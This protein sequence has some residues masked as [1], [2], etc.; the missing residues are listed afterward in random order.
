MMRTAAV[1]GFAMVALAVCKVGPDYQRP[2][3]PV[4]EAYKGLPGW[5]INTPSD[6][7]DKGEWWSVYNDPVLDQLER[8]V[9]VSNQTLKEFKATYREA[10]AT[11]A[12]A[13]FQLRSSDA[14]QALLDD[15][16]S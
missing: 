3:A 10:Q 5:K 6:A 15:A 16:V 2:T 1:L 8:Q 11:L 7:S 12:S 9:E 4:P 14:L 13:Y